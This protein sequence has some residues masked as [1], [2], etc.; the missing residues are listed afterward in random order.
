MS[1]HRW[2][3]EKK[4]TQ[5]SC[6]KKERPGNQEDSGLEATDLPTFLLKALG[7]LPFAG[8]VTAWAR[9]A[10]GLLFRMWALK[11]TAVRCLALDKVVTAY[12]SKS[13]TDPG[14]RE[15]RKDSFK[16]FIFLLAVKDRLDP[17]KWER[18]HLVTEMQTAKWLLKENKTKTKTS[19]VSILNGSMFKCFHFSLSS[20][21]HS[22]AMGLP[23]CK[24]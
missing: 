4:H 15:G 8:E 13:C 3:L 2:T 22:L 7:S 17:I 20:R 19:H 5:R 23:E 12:F 10:W 16:S 6:L 9:T 18:F 14:A 1:F 24:D 21:G 11:S